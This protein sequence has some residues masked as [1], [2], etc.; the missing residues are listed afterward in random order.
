[1]MMYLS[2]DKGDVY[3]DRA[4]LSATTDGG[5]NSTAGTTLVNTKYQSDAV[6]GVY[7]TTDLFTQRISFTLDSSKLQL[8]C[9]TSSQ[10]Y[11]ET[12]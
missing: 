3:E 5:V 7:D 10:L 9:T 2:L 1:M 12:F 6:V 4:C 8:C 11:I